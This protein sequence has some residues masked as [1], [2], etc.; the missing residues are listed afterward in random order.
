[1]ITSQ[2]TASVQGILREGSAN[3][4]STALRDL[5][6]QHHAPEVSLFFLQTIFSQ[7]SYWSQTKREDNEE[8]SVFWGMGGKPQ[9]VKLGLKTLTT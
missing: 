8:I 7:R 9:R 3:L 6:T 2:L 1:M 5:T 4:E